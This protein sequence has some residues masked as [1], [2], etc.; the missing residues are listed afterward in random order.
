MRTFRIGTLAAA[1]LFA[2]TLRAQPAPERGQPQQQ[3]QP[4]N[5]GGTDN[6]RPNWGPGGGGGGPNY[7]GYRP[8]PGIGMTPVAAQVEAMRAWLELIE[9]YTRMSRDP[10]SAGVAAVIG[11]NDLMRGRPP[12][13]AIAYFEKLLPDVKDEAIRRA[14]RFQL[15]EL[16]Q[17]SGQ[18]DRA[19][20]ILRAI[21]T[22]PA[23]EHKE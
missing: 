23:A 2:G 16:Y 22:A 9:R 8:N 11:T 6:P 10:V 1:C 4:V 21:M 5:V 13:E 19:L 12:E 17:K 3:P 18:R 20:E 7:S 14:I 15:I